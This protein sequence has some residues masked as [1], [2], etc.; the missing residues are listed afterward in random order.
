MIIEYESIWLIIGTMIGILIGM[1]WTYF[2][3]K[4]NKNEN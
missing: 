1:I 2:I 4:E 3:M